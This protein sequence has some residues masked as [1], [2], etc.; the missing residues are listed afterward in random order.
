MAKLNYVS[1][2]FVSFID[3][4]SNQKSGLKICIQIM[5]LYIY[6]ETYFIKI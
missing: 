3:S 2:I 6:L 5:W 4:K 1:K